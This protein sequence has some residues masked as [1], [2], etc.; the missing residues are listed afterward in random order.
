MIRWTTRELELIARW[1]ISK[2]VDASVHGWRAHV[3]EAMRS[4]LPRERWRA[5]DSL[6]QSKGLF[7]PIM[8]RLVLEKANE[9]NKKDE[10]VAGATKEIAI[11]KEIIEAALMQLPLEYILSFVARRVMGQMELKSA[12]PA[13]TVR[14]DQAYPSEEAHKHIPFPVAQHRHERPMV[15]VVGGNEKQRMELFNR[16]NKHIE[17]RSVLSKEPDSAIV[18]RGK[19]CSKIYLW[20]NFISHCKQNIAKSNFNR[21]VLFYYSGGTEKL[22]ELINNDFKDRS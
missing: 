20:T 3:V 13:A 22:A 21:D 9:E 2:N 16:V 5:P 19:F 10:L 17:L 12:Q 7:I 11:G 14:F 8:N 6:N 1:L 18:T 15:M 4:C